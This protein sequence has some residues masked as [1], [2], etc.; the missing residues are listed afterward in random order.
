VPD[1]AIAGGFAFED[2]IFKGLALG[3]PYFKLIGMAR[4]PLAAAMVG[5]TIGRRI[6]EGDLP[7]YVARFGETIEEIFITAPELKRRFG[8]DFKRIPPGAIG[9]YTYMQRLAQGLRQ[10]MCGSRKFALDYISREDI[11]ALTEEAARIS[12]I[13]HVMEVDRALAEHILNG[14][15]EPSQLA[16]R[17]F[18]R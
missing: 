2:Q 1:I 17:E 5:K 8:S 14:A 6:E 16:E 3:A 9:L 13:P 4:A 10:L 15:V 18:A 7:V 11:A 12:G